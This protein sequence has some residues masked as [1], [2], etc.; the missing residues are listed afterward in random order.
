ML[1]VSVPSYVTP[2]MYSVVVL[3]YYFFF[4]VSTGSSSNSRLAETTS[5]T[6]TD[7][8]P[9]AKVRAAHALALHSIHPII[10]SLLTCAVAMLIGPQYLPNQPLPYYPSNCVYNTITL[11]KGPWANSSPS[12]TTV[13]GCAALCTKLDCK[14][15]DFMC[16]NHESEN[17]TLS[18]R[19]T[20]LALPL[21]LSRVRARSFS[22]AIH[23]AWAL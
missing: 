8:V 18:V 15:F 5:R 3:T 6:N 11:R 20:G 4:C 21:S 17:C 19:C 9:V 10:Y 22:C 7:I 14:C 23:P 2:L 1:A 16:N 13:A 12:A